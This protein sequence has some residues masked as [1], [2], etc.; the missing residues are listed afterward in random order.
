MMNDLYKK[1]YAKVVGE[2]D[3][4][5]QMI[6]QKLKNALLSAEEM[7]LEAGEDQSLHAPL[8]AATSSGMS[9]SRREA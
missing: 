9:P 3:D 2:V 4:T 8:S 5:I 7:Y 6:G 1:M